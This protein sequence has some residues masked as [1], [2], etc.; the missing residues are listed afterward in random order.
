M[1]AEWL[2]A[3]GTIGTFAVITASAVAALIQLRHMRSGNQ[4]AAY[5]EC[6]ETMET[7]EFREALNFIRSEL[8]QRLKDPAV[9]EDLLQHGFRN[10]YSGVRLVANLLESMGLFVRTRMMEESIACELWSGIVLDTWNC[11]RPLTAGIRNKVA[12]GIWINFEYMA[13]LSKRYVERHPGGYYPAGA[14]RMPLE[15]PQAAPFRAR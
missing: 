11:M 12:P 4:I 15:G 2:T 1:S 8:P 9:L 13:F 14:E 5:N 10:E 3:I 7:A 6:R